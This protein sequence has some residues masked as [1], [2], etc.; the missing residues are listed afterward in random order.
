MRKKDLLPNTDGIR[1]TDKLNTLARKV[2]MEK[3]YKDQLK[4]VKKFPCALKKAIP[5]ISV[6]GIVKLEVNI[7]GFPFQLRDRELK[8]GLLYTNV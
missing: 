7:G 1:S 5:V 2:Q 4:N 3:K 6:S 8:N